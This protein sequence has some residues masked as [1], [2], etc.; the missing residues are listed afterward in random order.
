MPKID[1]MFVAAGVEVGVGGDGRVFVCVSEGVS[2][3]VCVRV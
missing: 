2:V 1:L 3:R